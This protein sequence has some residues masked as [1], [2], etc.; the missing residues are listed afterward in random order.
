M[1]HNAL[2]CIT[3]HH[4]AS[5]CIIMHHIALQ[6][7]TLHHNAS[8][9]ITIHHNAPHYI[10]THHIASQS[11]RITLQLNHILKNV[12]YILDIFNGKEQ[13]KKFMIFFDNFIMLFFSF[14]TKVLL[15][16]KTIFC[17]RCVN[18]YFCPN[19]KWQ[20]RLEMSLGFFL[21]IISNLVQ[22]YFPRIDAS[23]KQNRNEIFFP[24]KVNDVNR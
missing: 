5:H 22:Y 3:L 8:H 21:P 12:F 19:W 24:K 6:C 17:Q 10:T 7:I 1:P 23:K 15:K 4:N 2:Q 20:K 14:S 18:I 9:C 11:Y 13:S 16:T